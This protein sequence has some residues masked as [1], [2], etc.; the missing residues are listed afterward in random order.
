MSTNFEID[1]DAPILIDF[2]QP[3]LQPVAGIWGGGVVEQQK[4]LVE[5]SQKALDQAMNTIYHM[6]Q[7]VTDTMKALPKSELPNKVEVEFGI[8]LDAEAGAYIA[9]AGVEAS[10]T[11]TL[12]WERPEKPLAVLPSATSHG[13]EH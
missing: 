12:A 6:A 11:V 1:P 13:I 8:K 3:G 7:R 4:D 5:K 9:K 2:S 10:I